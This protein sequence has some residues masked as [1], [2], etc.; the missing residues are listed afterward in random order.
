VALRK[1]NK[2]DGWEQVRTTV[3]ANGTLRSPLWRWMHRNHD[4]LSALFEQAPPA[5]EV[6]VETFGGMGLTDRTAARYS[7]SARPARQTG[8]RRFGARCR[9]HAQDISPIRGPFGPD[10]LA[11]W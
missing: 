1:T 8:A 10:Q 3:I 6:L 11:R 7:R 9:L 2:A 4:R 5:W